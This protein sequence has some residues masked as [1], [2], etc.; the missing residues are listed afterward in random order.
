MIDFLIVTLAL[1][2]APLFTWACAHNFGGATFVG[3]HH[4]YIGFA[5]GVLGYFTGCWPVLLIGWLIALDDAVQHS[6]QVLSGDPFW[7]SPLHHLYGL[8]Y[9]FALIR[10]INEVLDELFG[11]D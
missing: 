9:G 3:F 1:V 11:K 4:F 5:L 7:H 6:A 2:L 10:T 8:I